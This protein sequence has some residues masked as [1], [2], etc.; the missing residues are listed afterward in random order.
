MKKIVNILT[1]ALLLFSNALFSQQESTFTLYRYHMNMVNPAYA[2]VDGQTVITGSVRRQWSGIIDAP[3]TQAVSFGTCLGKN[4]GFGISIVNDKVFIEKQ[5]T[6]GVDFSYKVKVDA[7]ANLYLG[8]KAGGSFYDVNTAGLRGMP[9]DPLLVSESTFNPNIGVG[10]LLKSK[11][12]FMSL[13]IPT[14]INSENS[15]NLNNPNR[16]IPVHKPHVYWSTGYDIN[17]NPEAS[18]VL[19][20]SFMLRYVN[21]SPVSVDFNTL[22]KIQ[23][24]A[25]FGGMYRLNKGYAGIVD[26][27]ISKRLMVG[28]AYESMTTATQLQGAGNTHEFFIKFT[29]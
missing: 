14:L 18:L 16:K 21:G 29:L 8:I 12:F 1:V 26:F 4:L 24:Y 7:V 6:V 23:Q 20:P 28:Y 17:L 11:S 25:E 13:S 19:K 3:S 9:N 10:A 27:T 22:L 5:N 2:G 15:R